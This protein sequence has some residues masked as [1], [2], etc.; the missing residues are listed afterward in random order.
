M[1]KLVFTFIAF[2]LFVFPIKYINT[3]LTEVRP[4]ASLSHKH[5][6]HCI[7]AVSRD[8]ATWHVFSMLL[9]DGE[10]CRSSN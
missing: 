7:K 2:P 3:E 9:H 4:L 6:T 8:A 5:F 10:E 1:I